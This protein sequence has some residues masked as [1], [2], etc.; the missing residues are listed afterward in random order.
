MA[1]AVA[2]PEEFGHHAPDI[3]TFGNSMAVA[4]MRT[5]NTVITA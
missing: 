5:D 2:A 4:P 1:V 3:G